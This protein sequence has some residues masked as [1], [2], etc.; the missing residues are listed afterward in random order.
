MHQSIPQDL[1]QFRMTVEQLAAIHEDA[2]N[3]LQDKYRRETLD[4][5]K[6]QLVPFYKTAEIIQNLKAKLV[7][8]RANAKN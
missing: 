6:F 1:H 4:L 2:L 7:G 3:K 8:R 5:E